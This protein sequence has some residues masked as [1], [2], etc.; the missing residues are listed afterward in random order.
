MAEHYYQISKPEF[1]S[2]Q[3]KSGQIL[4]ILYPVYVYKL[5]CAINNKTEI[6]V[7]QDSIFRL[8]ISGCLNME[9]VAALL[10]LDKELVLWILHTQLINGRG[11]LNDDLKITQKGQEYLDNNDNDETELRTIWAFQDGLTGEWLP[12]F[13]YPTDEL[14]VFEFDEKGLPSFLINRERGKK[15][16]PYRLNFAYSQNQHHDFS[17][18]LYI[19]SKEYISDFSFALKNGNKPL[20]Q[21]HIRK[22]VA[23]PQTS[24]KAWLYSYIFT[25]EL[26]EKSWL[27]SDPFGLKD[28]V[29][30]LRVPIA[31]HLKQNH[32]LA[33]K[34]AQ[35]LGQNPSDGLRPSQCLNQINEQAKLQLVVEYAWLDKV[36]NA[37]D[38][39]LSILK[40][41]KQLELS[42]NQH[43]IDNLLIQSQNLIEC[44][45]KYWIEQY[46]VNI[47]K[48]PN[49]KKWHSIE[50]GNLFD[51]IA[52]AL[53]KDVQNI[54]LRQKANE[55]FS[56]LFYNN[57]S[58]KATLFAVLL[59]TIEYPN[60]ILLTIDT[61][62]LQLGKL[63]EL[64]DK[65]NSVGH[66]SVQNLTKID[67][68]EGLFWA[69]F[70]V[71]WVKLF[72]QSLL[73]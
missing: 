47:K 44:I 1:S 37:T 4:P 26:S 28:A 67:K 23:T 69:E 21:A 72:Q 48:W 42:N 29:K 71:N 33:N 16:K 39:L 57:K 53:S 46:P 7:F 24:K 30:W 9:E 49:K 10:N 41:E 11:L 43:D 18:L 12:R 54:L 13:C 55:V 22:I 58:M 5:T 36:P 14:E 15:E 62:Q 32:H 40:L 34:I 59:S 20:K 70:T 25:H 27:V 2:E 35:M 19:P 51:Y 56:A 17:E 65:R 52:V 63:L 50:L 60:H 61:E 64:A 31:N 8:V 45:L 3:W 73:N 68:D 38:Y 6:N 66:A